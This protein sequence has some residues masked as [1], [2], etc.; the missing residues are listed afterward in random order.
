MGRG[1]L[2]SLAASAKNIG[3]LSK[4]VAPGKGKRRFAV[5]A[6][7]AATLAGTFVCAAPQTNAYGNPLSDAW[8][9]I[10]SLADGVA[11]DDAGLSQYTVQGV[12]PRGTTINLFDYWLQGRNADDFHRYDDPQ[13][14]D[15]DWGIN[16]GHK[17][18]FGYSI[19]TDSRNVTEPWNVSH[20]TGNKTYNPDSAD[21]V[22]SAQKSKGHPR[23]NIVQNV[24]G[25]DGYPVLTAHG[26]D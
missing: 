17:L 6:V 8:N 13:Y 21:P 7:A 10:T 20:W 1:I 3:G 18:Q 19:G 22:T 12:T 5:A 15:V 14:N 11:A 26:V 16:N 23:S 4:K 25:D 2:L 9:A 24:L